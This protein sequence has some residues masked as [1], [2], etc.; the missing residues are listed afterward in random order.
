ME[1][2]TKP[3]QEFNQPQRLSEV[4]WCVNWDFFGRENRIQGW[5]KIGVPQS[6]NTDI[7]IFMGTK[8]DHLWWPTGS[9]TAAQ[10]I[11]DHFP[12]TT[13]DD[14]CHHKVDV[15]FDRSRKHGHS[16]KGF[17]WRFYQI[18]PNIIAMEMDG[19]GIMLSKHGC[20]AVSWQ[21]WVCQD[22]VFQILQVSVPNLGSIQSI[23]KYS[24]TWVWVWLAPQ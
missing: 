10:I 12:D 9:C 2:W 8:N 13:I 23:P 19:N 3:K 14:D 15:G 5:H 1:I 21:A 18:Y 7:Q 6:P 22:A 17:W 11:E 16:T 4:N 20:E 24:M